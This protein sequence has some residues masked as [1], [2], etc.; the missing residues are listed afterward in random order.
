MT[1]LS[2]L[3]V[4]LVGET[5]PFVAAMENAKKTAKDAGGG[6][7]SSLNGALGAL[8]D[9]AK[10]A[11]GAAVAG[12]GAVAAGLTVA[13]KE[14]A[15]AEKNLAQLDAVLKSTGGAAGVTRDSVLELA[16]ALQNTTT[17][18]DDEVIAADNL[19]LTFTNI[20]KDVFP[21]ATRAVLDMSVALGQDAENSAIQLGK[22]LN[23]P[24]KGVTALRKVGVS[25]T[26]EQMKQIKAMQES[27][28]VMGA[29]KLI[30]KELQKEFGGSAEA[31]GKTLSGSLTILKNTGLDILETIGTALLPMLTQLAQ[32]LRDALDNP[33]VQAGIRAIM[34]AIGQFTT[35][36]IPQIVAAL[37]GVV[38]WVQTNWP[39]FSSE[40]SGAFQRADAIVRPIVEALSNFLK[41]IFSTI[42]NFL[43][44]HGEQIKTFI[45]NAWN[46]ISEI[47]SG[48]VTIVQT[49]IT[50]VFGGIAAWIN[51]NQA[52]IQAV[53]STVWNA[54]Q[55]T[56]GTVIEIVRGIINTVLA[57]IKGDWSTAW[58]SIKGVIETIWGGIQ[59]AI[60]LALNAIKSL[61]S[62]A[63]NAIK[64][65]VEMAWNGIRS[66]I[67]NAWQRV[68][69]FLRG[70]W[71]TLVNIGKN[72][73]EGIAAGILSAASAIWN[74]LKNAVEGAWN[75]IKELL[76]I[77]SPSRVYAEI[78]KQMM[79]GLAVGITRNTELP[80]QALNAALDGVTANITTS[81]SRARSIET[82]APTVINQYENHFY[83]AL[84]TKLWLE[85]QRLERISSTS[86]RM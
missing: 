35:Q 60:E 15:D 26:E 85:R 74:A 86:R 30:L 77:S 51:D 69:G 7:K 13:V 34:D 47:I 65:G 38:T 1:T 61:L 24:I 12:I 5:G 4:K 84:S 10:F 32:G 59:A 52:A 78:G 16:S 46:G 70:L 6:I 40:I 21:D 14:A 9:V 8:G 72:I 57:V 75:K 36:V 68:V 67:E 37:Q 43:S 44:T 58:E 83:D 39:R 62:L 23:D 18:S 80:Q 76:G 66:A 25:F 31:A 63:W 2:T 56:I 27:G 29:Q 79:A 20:G 28:D 50:D 19:L 11:A 45:G 53:I 22:A 82:Q 17:F 41:S 54:I 42:G 33:A 73:I 48:V 55:N 81:A 3:V 64:S 71:D 49:V